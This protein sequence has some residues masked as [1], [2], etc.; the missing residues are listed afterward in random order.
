MTHVTDVRVVRHKQGKDYLSA[1]SINSDRYIVCLTE[2]SEIV[3]QGRLSTSEEKS[4]ICSVVVE[5]EGD[6]VVVVVFVLDYLQVVLK[7][8]LFS[9]NVQARSVLAIFLLEAL[10]LLY[11]H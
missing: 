2:V 10:F 4:F 9:A 3:T 7:V 11:H 1:P 5:E 6:C 8:L